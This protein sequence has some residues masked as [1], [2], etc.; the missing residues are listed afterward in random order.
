MGGNRPNPVNLGKKPLYRLGEER[1]SLARKLLLRA[2][3]NLQ[4]LDGQDASLQ[5]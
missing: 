4:G 1:K 3:D 2:A 5:G